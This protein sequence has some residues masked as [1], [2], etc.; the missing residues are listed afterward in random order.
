MQLMCMALKDH[1][2]LWLT[3]RQLTRYFLLTHPK[4]AG[5]PLTVE[6]NARQR[7]RKKKEQENLSSLYPGITV[8]PDP[9][10]LMPGDI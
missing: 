9:P 7:R 1:Y 10:S 8:T 5:V 4:L 3:V 6:F 2:L